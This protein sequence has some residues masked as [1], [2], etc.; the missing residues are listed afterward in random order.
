MPLE[1]T[2]DP[3]ATDDLREQLVELW[4]RVS[5]SG[6][7]VGFVPPVTARDVAPAAERH[8]A[9]MA[10]GRTRLLAAA[11]DGKLVGT[12]FLAANTHRLMRHWCWLYTVMLDPAAQGRGYGS[13]L[14]REAERAARGMGF[15]GVRLTCR[16][17]LGLE[18]FYTS[19]GYQEVGRVPA[20]I[21][22]APDDD[23]D[24]VTMWL[25]LT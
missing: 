4:V 19:M 10:E 9:A 23:R 22:V 12:V 21:R 25:A 2:L 5:N 7:A 1:F 15:E 17:G 8:L 24:D 18:R 3:P 6:G 16:G 14:L 20:A 11:E 13:R